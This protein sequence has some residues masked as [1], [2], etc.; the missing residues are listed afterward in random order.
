MQALP[1]K[2]RLTMIRGD[3]AKQREEG[4]HPARASPKLAPAF[5]RPESPPKR[6]ASLSAA[7]VN[8]TATPV[9]EGLHPA[10]STFSVGGHT[11]LRL[12]F[13]P[14]KPYVCRDP[15]LQLECDLLDSVA[16]NSSLSCND[17][18]CHRCRLT[19]CPLLTRP[20]AQRKRRCRSHWHPLPHSIFYPYAR[21][22]M[23]LL[24]SSHRCVRL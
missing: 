22:L 9:R 20:M 14:S 18:A 12:L 2:A 11:G 13:G 15:C 4:L 8:L 3:E 16:A 19:F 1:V 6:A 21:Q 24:Q 7:P 10:R 17:A 23:R 5:K